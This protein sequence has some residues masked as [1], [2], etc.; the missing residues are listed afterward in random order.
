ME[1]FNGVRVKDEPKDSEPQAETS[2]IL[3]DLLL[4]KEDHHYDTPEFLTLSQ[5]ENIEHVDSDGHNVLEEDKLSECSTKNDD[6]SYC[7]NRSSSSDEENFKTRCEICQE[8]FYCEEELENHEANRRRAD[9][10]FECCQCKK[11]FR[12]RT[13]LNVHARKHTGEKPYECTIC[14]KRFTV[15]GNLNKHMRIHTGERRFECD[16]CERKFTQF[17]HLEDHMK[18]HYGRYLY[19]N[20]IL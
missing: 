6:N 8:Q 11:A 10:R 3:E 20:K 16:T 12:D 5:V 19:K 13:Q 2:N 14:K 7:S 17:A 18:T 4:N 9:K 15:N 1:F